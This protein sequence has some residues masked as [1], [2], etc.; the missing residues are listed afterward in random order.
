[1]GKVKVKKFA[2]VKEQFNWLAENQSLLKAQRRSEPKKSDGHSYG[3]TSF[4][5]ND[6]GERIKA[7]AANTEDPSE[8]KGVLKVKCVINATNI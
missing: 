2:T 8:D 5:V 1:M 6:R 7:D 4:A 3:F